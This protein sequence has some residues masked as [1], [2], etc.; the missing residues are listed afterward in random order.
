MLERSTAAATR[1]IEA[2]AAKRGAAAA[3]GRFIMKIGRIRIRDV[4]ERI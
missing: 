4:Y 2:K 1:L 3:M